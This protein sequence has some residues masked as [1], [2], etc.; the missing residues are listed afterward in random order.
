MPRVFV[1]NFD[2]EYQLGPHPLAQ[3][4]KKLQAI[5][6]RL[7]PALLPLTAPGDIIWSPGGADA[8][9]ENELRHH[10]VELQTS[11]TELPVGQDWE[12][13]PWGWT[14]VLLD[15]ARQQEWTTHAPSL[16]AVAWANSRVTS[17]EWEQQWQTGPD[18]LKLIASAK[19]VIAAARYIH[20]NNNQRDRL[21]SW[22]IKAEFGMSSRERLLGKGAELTVAQRN[23]IE[24]RLSRGE[25]LVLE[26]W[27]DRVAER[28]FHFD[29]FSDRTVQR[30]GAVALITDTAGRYLRNSSLEGEDSAEAEELWTEAGEVAFKAAN[31][32]AEGGYFGPVSIDSMLYQQEGSLKVR[33]L[34]D[35]NA[36]WSMGR[37]ELARI[38]R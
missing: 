1:G 19:D 21:A 8:I 9:A 38:S 14:K 27:L 20:S 35:I 16:D 36:R 13:V 33:P 23:W 7:L 3:L 32:L 28:S 34:Q 37:C 17:A 24:K 25:R 26:P 10:Q 31:A 12:I 15:Q 30:V 29:I 2:F 11:I 18:R 5:N 22:I 6:H 4:P